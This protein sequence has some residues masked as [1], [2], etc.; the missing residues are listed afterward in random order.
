MERIKIFEG[1]PGMVQED[2]N[3]FI[4]DGFK[5]YDVKFSTCCTQTNH[6]VSTVLVHYEDED[7]EN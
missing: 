2:L 5:F 6:V 7:G 1:S 4:A 3:A